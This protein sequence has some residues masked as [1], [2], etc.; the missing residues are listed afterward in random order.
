MAAEHETA[1]AVA[2]ATGHAAEAAHGAHG[3]AFDPATT[4]FHH[5]LDSQTLELPFIGE[6]HL[7]TLHLG[8]WNLPITKHVVMMWVASLIVIMVAGI[9]ARRRA[10]V[11]GRVQ[12]LVEMLV[13]FVRDELA[14]KNIGHGGDR[15]V[16]FL[17]TAFF[18]I[19][20]CNFLGLVP[21]GATATSNIGVTATLAGLT[22]IMTQAAGI[23]ENGF[24]GYI[25]SIVPP[26][27]PAWLLPIMIPV[28]IIGLFTKP[29]AL[30][31]RLFA[32]MFAGHAI[33][34]A[35]ICLVFI[36]KS[37]LVGFFLTVPFALFI[38]GIELMVAF[39]QAFIFTML[40][41]LFIGMSAHPSH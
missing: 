24:F 39:L 14:R 27:I 18:F 11:P 6:V 34:M 13:L 21:Y 38:S 37:V 31:V 19:L 30:A 4:I 41:S 17:L 23:R 22:F 20:G 40:S 15:Y 28:E 29:F 36:L 12:S 26:G 2:E 32:N 7:P 25:H 3:G 35:L 1:Q 8:S 16:P 10:M 5:L 9:A 33:I